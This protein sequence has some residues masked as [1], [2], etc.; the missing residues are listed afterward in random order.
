VCKTHDSSVVFF[1]IIFQLVPIEGEKNDNTIKTS[2]SKE[3]IKGSQ[4]N[5]IGEE[6]HQ[7]ISNLTP[8]TGERWASLKS[9]TSFFPF[10]GSKKEISLSSPTSS[11]TIKSN[12][13]DDDIL[14]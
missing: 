12:A 8:K 9:P 5:D 3:I 10:A 11:N 7:D 13:D 2:E 4:G 14:D 1:V 6:S